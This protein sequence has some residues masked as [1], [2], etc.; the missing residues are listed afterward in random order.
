ML[1]EAVHLIIEPSLIV[2]VPVVGLH[3]GQSHQEMLI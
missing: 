2:N 1:L 3:P